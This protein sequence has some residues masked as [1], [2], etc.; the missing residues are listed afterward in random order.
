MIEY[1]RNPVSAGATFSEM[2]RD[3]MLAQVQA[4]VRHVDHH[5]PTWTQKC[6]RIGAYVR[7]DWRNFRLSTNAF[8][9]TYDDIQ[10]GE[11]F[12]T[13]TLNDAFSFTTETNGIH[14]RLVY[15]PDGWPFFGSP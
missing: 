15:E 10:S 5:R 2:L 11:S 14:S 9:G 7:R 1:H 8:T 12:D 6:E 13:S 3:C 4:I